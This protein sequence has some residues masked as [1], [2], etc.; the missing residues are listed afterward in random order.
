MYSEEK[1]LQSILSFGILASNRSLASVPD[2]CRLSAVGMSL[3]VSISFARFILVH[4]K[5]GKIQ[6][7][8]PFRNLDFFTVIN[9]QT[10]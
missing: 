5:Y 9:G 1:I 2:L 3:L 6:N 8:H 4:P 7:K 10:Q